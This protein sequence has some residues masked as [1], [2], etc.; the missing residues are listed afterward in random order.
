MRITISNSIT[1]TLPDFDIVAL[2]M[3][4]SA[5]ETTVDI[6]DLIIPQSPTDEDAI[7]KIST[8]AISSTNPKT[9]NI[10]IR[11]TTTP[12][13]FNSDLDEVNAR[14]DALQGMIIS[15]LNGSY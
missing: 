4:V 15:S 8:G 11:Y 7:V 9:P 12:F 13:A 1:N 14:V 2:K 3:D 6:K 5:N 10:E